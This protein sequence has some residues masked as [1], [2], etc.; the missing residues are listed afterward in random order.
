MQIFIKI[1]TYPLGEK[2]G[3]QE[4]Y[5]SRA[6]DF[7]KGR[8]LCIAFCIGNKKTESLQ[9]DEVSVMKAFN[10]RLL[11]EPPEDRQS[12][13]WIGYDLFMK[14]IPWLRQRAIKYQ[15]K[16]L[17][18]GLINGGM[19]IDLKK[20]FLHPVNVSE[21]N[22]TL[23]DVCYFFDIDCPGDPNRWVVDTVEAGEVNKVRINCESIVRSMKQLLKKLPVKID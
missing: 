22:A 6:D 5:L 2:T 19:A 16:T 20:D 3:D 4:E 8:I 21:S 12:I 10:E 18:D 11:K 23:K 1:T 9:G 14:E 13:V 7:L 17:L 15:C